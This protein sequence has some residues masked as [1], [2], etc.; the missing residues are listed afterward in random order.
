M[1]EEGYPIYLWAKPFRVSST[2]VP[3]ELR[4]P[5]GVKKACTVTNRNL[6]D[7]DFNLLQTANY[8]ISGLLFIQ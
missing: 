3:A 2:C 1:T 5:K 7:P 8:N 6:A 4:L